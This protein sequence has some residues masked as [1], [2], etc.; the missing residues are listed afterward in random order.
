MPAQIFLNCRASQI[1]LLTRQNAI[2]CYTSSWIKGIQLV[3][4]VWQRSSCGFC[5]VCICKKRNADLM[6]PHTDCLRHDGWIMLGLNTTDSGKAQQQGQIQLKWLRLMSLHLHCFTFPKE[7]AIKLMQEGLYSH[8]LNIVV[9]LSLY[10][11]IYV[12][13]YTHMHCSFSIIKVAYTF[14]STYG[15]T[16]LSLTVGIWSSKTNW[17]WVHFMCLSNFKHHLLTVTSVRCSVIKNS[18]QI[19][20]LVL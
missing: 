1:N 10:I 3:Q 6:P 18:N 14:Y 8:I 20:S 16:L 11:C 9:N 17:D 2:F 15:H 5:K 7:V 13:I 19:V 4:I 12:Y